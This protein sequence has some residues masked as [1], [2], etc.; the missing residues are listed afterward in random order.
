MPR[1]PLRA[2]AVL[3][4]VS[5]ILGG[6]VSACRFDTAT[7][8]SRG[9]NEAVGLIAGREL[10]VEAASY[11]PSGF[12]SPDDVTLVLSSRSDDCDAHRKQVA[13]PDATTLTLHLVQVTGAGTFRVTRGARGPG[14]ALVRFSA[15]DDD[16]DESVV[17]D[18]DG[19]AV[20]VTG[21]DASSDGFI[22]GSF[23][24]TFD[25]ER[26]RGDF[27]TSVCTVDYFCGQPTECEK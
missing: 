24:V 25:G 15:L 27:D 23:D 8:T 5:A 13:R 18:A 6:T 9:S 14:D 2:V 21:I 10:S 19:G 7:D 16:C 26:L 20:T 3:A 17:R 12:G 11:C 4:A 22:K 1:V